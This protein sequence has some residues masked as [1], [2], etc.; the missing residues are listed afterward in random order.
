[1]TRLMSNKTQG[2]PIFY[3]IINT[4]FMQ[5]SYGEECK[6]IIFIFDNICR[7]KFIVENEIELCKYSECFF[8][9]MNMRV[10]SLTKKKS[11]DIIFGQH[12][13]YYK[14]SI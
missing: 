14:F 2:Q 13:S 6:N 4:G 10:I 8:S 3:N 9:S 11:S 1:M 7:F 5:N 12:Q